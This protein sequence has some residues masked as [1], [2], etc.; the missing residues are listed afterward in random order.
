MAAARTPRRARRDHPHLGPLAL[1]GTLEANLRA[2]ERVRSTQSLTRAAVAVVLMEDGGHPSVPIFQRSSGMRRH[3]GQMALPGGRLNE[4]E[5]PEDCA[6]R[7][8]HE[9]V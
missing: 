9:E 4:G 7:E 1:R 8:L 3:A 2:F 6:I 5:S